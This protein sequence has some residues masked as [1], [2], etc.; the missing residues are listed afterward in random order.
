MAQVPPVTVPAG[1]DTDDDLEADPF[2]GPSA[3]QHGGDAGTNPFPFSPTH[4]AAAHSMGPE[5]MMVMMQQMTQAAAAASQAAVAAVSALNR[6]AVPVPGSTTAGFSDANRILKRPDEFGSSSHDH[7]LA[8]WQEWAHGFKWLIFADAAFEPELQEIEQNVD[9][10]LDSA[11][12]ST[13]AQARSQ[14]L[15]AILASLLK[16]KPRTLLRQVQ[17]RNGY[18]VFRQL[19]GVYAP[20]SKARSLAILNAVVAMPPFSKEKTLREQ[21]ASLERLATE[22][23]RI[24][25]I[26]GKSVGDDVLLG[27]VLRCL[28]QAIRQH[29]QLQMSERTTYATVRDYVLTYETT[30][31]QWS[32]TKVH[33]S[34]GVVAPPPGDQE[35]VPM[36]LNRVSQLIAELNR[37]KGGKK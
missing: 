20:R 29:I 31:T 26:T 30:T 23:E 10:V 35:P 14:R 3:S 25:R 27:T 17:G 4:S 37:I 12:M 28:P 34:L 32:T 16:A 7:D 36:D 33:Q 19:V 5:A 1:N 6:D 22:Y 15:Y 2:A 9:R 18:E 8:I 24:R 11:L 13:A 21:L